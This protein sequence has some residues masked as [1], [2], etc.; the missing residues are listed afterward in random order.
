[1]E[2][3]RPLAKRRLENA[4]ERVL[5]AKALG[6]SAVGLADLRRIVALIGQEKRF[7][8]FLFLKQQTGFLTD[9]EIA[10]A[11]NE[12]RSNVV[13][14]LY[15][16]VSE[17]LVFPRRDKTTKIPSFR[18]NAEVLQSLTELFN[19][20]TRPRSKDSGKRS[21]EYRTGSLKRRRSRAS[22]RAA[23]G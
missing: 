20:A 19:L 3:T 6:T 7:L 17:G 15:A 8:L 12:S 18:I 5:G 14:N 10:A 4:I 2:P 13:R 1:M 11:I 16:F 22:T 23:D 21:S 9:Y